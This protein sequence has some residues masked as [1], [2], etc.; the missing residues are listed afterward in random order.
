MVVPVLVFL[1]V[2]V[3]AA[4]HGFVLDDYM[5]VLESR[6]RSLSDLIA[7]FQQD[8]GFYRP[9]VAVSFAV[10]EW[11]AGVRP[12]GYGLVNVGLAVLCGASIA[13]LA[14][15]FGLSWG[16]SVF[17]GAMWMLNLQGIR[18]AVLWISGRT[19]LIVILAATMS[20][21]AFVK[22]QHIVS[23][24]WLALAVFAKEEAVLLPLV[25]IGWMTL[26]PASTPHGW[27]WNLR[28][29]V[30]AV[31]VVA[32]YFVARS[33]TQAMTMV[34]APPYYR[35]TFE[36]V[37]VLENLISYADRV[38]TV[39][40]ALT[41]LA[42][43]VLGVRRRGTDPGEALDRPGPGAVG[44]AGAIWTIGMFGITLF[45]PVRSDLYACL[46]AVGTCLIAA[47]VC[48][49][50]WARSSPARQRLALIG[51]MA[52]MLLV[53]P[54]YVLRTGRYVQPAEFAA[55]TLA[56]LQPLVTGITPD[57]RVVIDD[58]PR[59]PIKGLEHRNLSD[60]FGALLPT[61]YELVSGRRLI[62]EIHP[63]P[64][65]APPT[66]PCESCPSLRLA[67]VNGRVQAGR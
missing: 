23:L 27:R 8:N 22:R 48:D 19:A 63:P 41:L 30:G 65:N 36:P 33:T 64:A 25:F 55:A 46:P 56:D 17:A 59:S 28:W 14:R 13:R 54:V 58:E 26:V 2:Y 3:P 42:M 11:F 5:W 20:A 1:G 50:L 45:V 52:L 57:G 24:I 32:A 6:V 4:G 12:L 53:S 15:A 61:A 37:R 34:S 62:F 18:M 38:A 10:N 49:R 43:L 39:P 67:I 44:L 9:I 66:P 7:L 47:A 16:A 31:I 40:L 29:I 60:A 51:A 35:L 21:T